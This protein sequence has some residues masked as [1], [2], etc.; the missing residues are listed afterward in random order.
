MHKFSCPT[1]E[2]TCYNYFRFAKFPLGS[3]NAWIQAAGQGIDWKP[4]PDDLVCSKHFLLQ[5]SLPFWPFLHFALYLINF[6]I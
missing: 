5:V 4:S 6:I 3:F 1:R 2:L